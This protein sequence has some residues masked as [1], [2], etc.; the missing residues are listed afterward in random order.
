[1]STEERI[2][3]LCSRLEERSRSAPRGV[4][5]QLDYRLDRLRQ[6]LAQVDVAICSGAPC[7]A[8][9]VFVRARLLAHAVVLLSRVRALQARARSVE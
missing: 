4:C 9:R 7:F 3:A 1:M 5:R 6:T 2:R 8:F